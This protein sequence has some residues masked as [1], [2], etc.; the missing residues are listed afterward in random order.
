MTVARNFRRKLLRSLTLSYTH[1][2]SN[3]GW[4]DE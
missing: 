4:T 1:E 3:T 2:E